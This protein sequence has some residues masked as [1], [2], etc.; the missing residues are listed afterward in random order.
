M[1]H[2]LYKGD[3]CNEIITPF[4]QIF[5][6]SDGENE[7]GIIRDLVKRFAEKNVKKVGIHHF[8]TTYNSK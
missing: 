3:R 1:Q 4:K 7:D 8:H 6:D 5:T 2:T